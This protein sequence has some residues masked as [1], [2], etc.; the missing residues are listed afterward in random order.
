MPKSIY[1]SLV[2]EYLESEGYLVYANLEVPGKWEVDILA[3]SPTKRCIVGEVKRRKAEQRKC[4]R[5][6]RGHT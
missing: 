2:R 6:F 1:E 5:N 4:K 3:Y